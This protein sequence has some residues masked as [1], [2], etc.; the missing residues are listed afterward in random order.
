MG[1]QSSGM[2]EIRCPELIE[3]T[4]LHSQPQLVAAG[5]RHFCDRPLDEL[6]RAGYSVRR[7]WLQYMRNA[8]ARFERDGRN[9]TM[10]TDYFRTS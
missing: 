3:I 9:Q 6:L 5:D 8:R 2:R 4:H 7:R 10:I 1:M